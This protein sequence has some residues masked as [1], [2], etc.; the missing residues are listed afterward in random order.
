MTPGYERE[1]ECRRNDKCPWCPMAY[2]WEHLPDRQPRRCPTC[3]LGK[4]Q[5]EAAFARKEEERPLRRFLTWL[6]NK[7][8]SR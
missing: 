6:R 3:I 8:T 5:V 4:D 7:R 1:L 2:F